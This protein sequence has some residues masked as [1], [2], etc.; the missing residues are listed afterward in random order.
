MVAVWETTKM[1]PN[2]A[3]CIMPQL[4][5]RFCSGGNPKPFTLFSYLYQISVLLVQDQG[6]KVMK[7]CKV[8]GNKY[9]YRNSKMFNVIDR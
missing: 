9:F 7:I 5:L 4:L 6:R 1:E 2:K 3:T 8:K